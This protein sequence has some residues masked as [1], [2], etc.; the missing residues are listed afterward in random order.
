MNTQM[1]LAE[2]LGYIL[3]YAGD[4]VHSY[5]GDLAFEDCI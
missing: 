2:L 1:A 5:F 3:R 4:F